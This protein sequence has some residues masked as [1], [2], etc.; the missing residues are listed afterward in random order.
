VRIAATLGGFFG[1]MVLLVVYKSRCRYGKSAISDV[2]LA[3]AAAAVEEEEQQ[4]SHLCK[5]DPCFN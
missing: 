2:Q 3:A 5:S 4:V 1:M